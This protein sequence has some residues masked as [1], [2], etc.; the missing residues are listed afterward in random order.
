MLGGNLTERL[1]PNLS[2]SDRSGFKC[3][4]LGH[5]S[6]IAVVMRD[7]GGRAGQGQRVSPA[8]SC[9][10]CCIDAPFQCVWKASGLEYTSYSMISV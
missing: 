6:D 7:V 3:L 2:S 1:L 8:V 10:I 9:L 5:F 4:A